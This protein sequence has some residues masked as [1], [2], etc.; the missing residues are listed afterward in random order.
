MQAQRLMRGR[1]QDPQIVASRK[2]VSRGSVTYP[3]GEMPD[4]CSTSLGSDPPRDRTF[5]SSGSQ[6]GSGSRERLLVI[7]PVYNE[8]PHIEAVAS[9][10]AEQTRPPDEWIV[11]DDGSTDGTCEILERLRPR[12]PFLRVVPLAVA[13]NSVPRDRLAAGRPPRA[14]NVGIRAAASGWHFVAKIDGDIELPPEYFAHLLGQFRQDQSLGI[15]SGQLVE[16]TRLGRWKRV[17]MPTHHVPGPVKVYRRECLTAIG[18]VASQLGW[19]TLDEMRARMLGWSTFSDRVLT[20]RHLRRMGT[21]QGVLRGRARHGTCAWTAHYPAYF[22]ALRS[23][24][25]ATQTPYGLSGAAFVYGYARAALT[26]VPRVDDSTLRAH[27]RRE[28]RERVVGALWPISSGRGT[29]ELGVDLAN[30]IGADGTAAD[31]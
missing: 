22:V 17:R 9:A 3:G 21:A 28:L 25:V 23:L 30:G 7:S 13:E 16:L 10:M 14:F 12:I 24:K 1:P 4:R 6:R 18:G 27:V 19:D 8:A 29:R 2:F 5:D 11:V 20:V 26:S 15:A 31:S